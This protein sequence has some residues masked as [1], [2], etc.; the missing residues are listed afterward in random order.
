MASKIAKRLLPPK[1]LCS[2]LSN[3][4]SWSQVT[5]LLG[6]SMGRCGVKW[7][8]PAALIMGT[9]SALALKLEPG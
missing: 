9:G 5:G 2:R 7:G 1:I 8:L 3:L 6:A 4:L